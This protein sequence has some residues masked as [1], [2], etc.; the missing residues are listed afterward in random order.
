MKKKVWADLW[1]NGRIQVSKSVTGVNVS[2]SG[3]DDDDKDLPF[4]SILTFFFSITHLVF[5]CLLK[6]RFPD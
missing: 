2:N 5:S 1:N 4:D 6:M 3:K